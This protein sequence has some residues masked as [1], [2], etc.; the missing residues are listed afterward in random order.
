MVLENFTNKRPK[1]TRRSP[2][3]TIVNVRKKSNSKRVP[4]VARATKWV[5]KLA[6]R[7]VAK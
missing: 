2:R 1:N 6:T 3:K 7:R 4:V 5:V